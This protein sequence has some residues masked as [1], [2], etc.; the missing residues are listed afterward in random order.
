MAA[1]QEATEPEPLALHAPR[2][3]DLRIARL[4][5]RTGATALARAELEW[6]AGQEALEPD[7]LADLAVARWRTGDPDAAAEAA[8]RHL[9]AQGAVASLGALVVAAEAAAAAGRAEDAAAFVGRAIEA[10]DGTMIEAV[11]GGQLSV[12][13]WPDDLRPA[14]AEGTTDGTPRDP[15]RVAQ[16]ELE[17]GRV[18][19]AALRLSLLLRRDPDLA[20]PILALLSERTSPALELVRGDAL[21]TLSR[22]AEAERAFAAAEAELDR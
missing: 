19:G 10:G 16:Q 13:P 9:E 2:P 18:D 7:A 8:A 4:H 22:E 14:T 20:A 12:A 5:L 1:D 3:M 17:A 15:L 6:L 11:L 21:R